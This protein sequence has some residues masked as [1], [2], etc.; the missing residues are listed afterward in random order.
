MTI[1]QLLKAVAAA[2]ATQAPV[3]IEATVRIRIGG[4]QQLV[5]MGTGATVRQEPERRDDASR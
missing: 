5:S 4:P 2:L 1:E 3:E